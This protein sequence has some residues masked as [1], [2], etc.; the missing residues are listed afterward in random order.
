[1]SLQLQQGSGVSAQ[2]SWLAFA[3]GKCKAIQLSMERRSFE[4]KLETLRVVGR[5]EQSIS[6][7][8]ERAPMSSVQ[9]LLSAGI[10]PQS[11]SKHRSRQSQS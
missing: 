2:V 4:R 1:M 10:S 6:N 11:C 9:T 5:R 3:A 8:F 7:C